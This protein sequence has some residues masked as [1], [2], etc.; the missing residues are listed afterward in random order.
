[1][2]FNVNARVG[3]RT[4]QRQVRIGSGNVFVVLLAFAVLAVLA[5]VGITV[6][7]G[8]VLVMLVLALLAASVRGVWRALGGGRGRGASGP[9]SSRRGGEWRE[10]DGGRTLRHGE[11]E[12]LPP[13]SAPR[14]IERGRSSTHRDGA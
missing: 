9:P 8:G 12:V 13:G 7:I 1:M 4:T 10:A 3:N 6:L 14:G 11:I 2:H 5:T